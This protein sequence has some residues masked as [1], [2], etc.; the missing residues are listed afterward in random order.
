MNPVPSPEP[1]TPRPASGALRA[2]WRW[3]VL[4]WPVLRLVIGA[5]LGLFV[6][7]VL[8]SQTRE[9]NGLT[10]AFTRFGWIW[11][12]PALVVESCSFVAFAIM[13]RRLLAA[14]KVRA[15]LGPL[16]RITLAS[17]AITNSLP[18]GPA[19]AAVYG[20]RWFRR[21][22]A[23]DAI[24]GWALVGTMIIATL[25]LAL[26]AA[27]GAVLAIGQSAN[28][29]LIPVVFGVLLVA[30]ALGALFVYERPIAVVVEWLV[31]ASVRLTGRPRGDAATTI[32]RLVER[33]TVVRLHWRDV[34][35]VVSWGMANWLLDCACF[36]F[37]FLVVGAPIP[38]AGLLLAYGAGQLAANLPITPGGL[39]AVEGSITIALVAFG[40]AETSTVEAVLIYRLISFWGELVIGW[41]SA[42]TLAWEVRRGRWPRSTRAV[43]ETPAAL[44][45]D[46][47]VP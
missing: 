20:F 12:V 45:T 43:P 31:L 44:A 38:W 32:R 42:G 16:A 13:M 18:A 30:L 3:V 47:V 11:L 21:L 36:A 5:A 35:T 46:A 7:Y 17:Q 14:G 40:G 25:S 26:C 1:D 9:L 28:F 15:R 10:S 23:D 4:A 8:I 33:V 2:A 27:L 22:G 29:D 34:L 37:A 24:A 19:F 6:I 41:V 39:G